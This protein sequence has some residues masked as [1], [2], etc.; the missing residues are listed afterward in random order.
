MLLIVCADRAS[1]GDRIGE[2]VS[3]EIAAGHIP[4][5]VILLEQHGG[6]VYR[7]AFGSMSLVPA[8]T[9]MQPDANFDLASLTKVLA[10]T[11]AIMQLA[12]TGRLRL[13]AA[14][15]EYWPAFAS[16]GKSAIIVRQPCR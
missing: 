5:A 6:I 16:A 1:A 10:T 15:A 8:A 13:D 12:E 7:G 9:A 4:G 11:T 3:Q 2:I 14:V